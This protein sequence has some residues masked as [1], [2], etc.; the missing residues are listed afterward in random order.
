MQEVLADSLPHFGKRQIINISG[1]IWPFVH[2]MAPGDWVV[3][4]SKS[5]PAIH[6]AEITGPY[7]FDAE[8]GDPYYHS[9]RVRWLVCHLPRSNFDQDLLYSFGAF[10]TICQIS[11]HQ[12]EQRVRAMQATQWRAVSPPVPAMGW[13]ERGVSEEAPSLE[14][15]A[16]DQLARQVARR[17]RGRDLEY[18]VEAILRA[19]DY[20]TY[21][22]PPGPDIG[23]DILAA[24]GAFGFGT[25][26]LCVQVKSGETAVDLPTFNQLLGAMH[27]V[28]AEQGLLVSWGGF[29]SSVEKQI[30]SQFFHVRL[31]DSDDL[32][33]ELFAVYDRLDQE[34]R[35]DLPLKHV[36]VLAA[37]ETVG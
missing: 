26:R 3:V 35:A 28:Q 14:E 32:I 21:R 13:D 23:I 2:R 30:P 33:R 34:L 25:P 36:W 29:K 18:L 22:P 5:E 12:A 9:R 4:P 11:R 10:M 24:P 31:W 27:S 7:L 37:P 17:Y 20:T 8:A 6:I 19:H 16:R 15:I 1:Q